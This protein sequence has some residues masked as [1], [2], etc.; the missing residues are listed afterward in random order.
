MHSSAIKLA[1]PCGSRV[2]WLLRQSIFI[3]EKG[4]IC[5]TRI[6]RLTHSACIRDTSLIV[7]SLSEIITV[8]ALTSMCLG[9]PNA[10]VN[11]IHLKKFDFQCLGSYFL[12]CNE[13]HMQGNLKKYGN[14]Y[15][16]GDSF[17]FGL[18]PL[19]LFIM[20]SFLGCLPVLV[21]GLQRFRVGTVPTCELLK[22]LLYTHFVY[23]ILI[24]KVVPIH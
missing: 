12:G 20:K 19:L 23:Y 7:I 1:P 13:K 11:G 2:S 21:C 9:Y 17:P 10:S 22:L 8:L 15:L 24:T 16:Q 5:R 4:L 3:S 6:E 18:H 14:I